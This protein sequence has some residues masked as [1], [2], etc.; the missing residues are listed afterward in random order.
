MWIACKNDTPKNTTT[1]GPI[2]VED[3]AQQCYYYI[4]PKDMV[5][6]RFRVT[7]K[8]ITGNLNYAFAEKDRNTGMIKGHMNGDT[9]IADYTFMSEGVQSV[10]E[11]AFL[12]TGDTF[13]EGY[14][15]MKE[16]NNKLC[17]MNLKTIRFDSQVVLSKMDCD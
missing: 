10:R 15:E 7:S 8:V 14:G 17:F 4:T 5:S 12:K 16:E 3:T 13:T 9:L 1:T 11:V 2:A 6:L